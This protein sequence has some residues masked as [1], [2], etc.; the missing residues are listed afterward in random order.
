MMSSMFVK[1]EFVVQLFGRVPLDNVFILH[2]GLDIQRGWLRI[3]Y[4]PR[5]FPENPPRKWQGLNSTIITMDFVLCNG[6]PIKV[7]LPSLK[8]AKPALATIGLEQSSE[9]I[10]CAVTGDITIE[11]Q[12]QVVSIESVVGRLHSITDPG[13]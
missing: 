9:W 6:R 13:P 1:E 12:C 11:C 2:V 8:F 7:E 10:Q 5:M 4:N 3:V